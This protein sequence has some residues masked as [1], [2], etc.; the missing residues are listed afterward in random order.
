MQAA[1]DLD[2]LD[3][4]GDETARDLYRAADHLLSQVK[5]LHEA[6]DLTDSEYEKMNMAR[7][8]L[9]QVRGSLRVRATEEAVS[10]I[11]IDDHLDSLDEARTLSGEIQDKLYGDRETLERLD[12]WPHHTNPFERGNEGHDALDDAACALMALDNDDE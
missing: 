9:A 4:D 6:D 5:A 11:E 12:D 10:C 1:V 7:G 8:H 2:D 3:L